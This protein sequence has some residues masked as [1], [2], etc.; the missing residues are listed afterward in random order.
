[1]HVGGVNSIL[2]AAEMDQEN[3]LM[4]KENLVGPARNAVAAL[5]RYDCG[6]PTGRVLQSVRYLGFGKP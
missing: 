3:S 6:G 1:M 4:V 2:L 5:A